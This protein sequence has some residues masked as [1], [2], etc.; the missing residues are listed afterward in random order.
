MKVTARIAFTGPKTLF[1][2]LKGRAVLFEYNQQMPIGKVTDIREEDNFIVADMEIIE[3]VWEKNK[4]V[5]D[6]LN[7]GYW[8]IEPSY[9]IKKQHI[10]NDVRV[11][12]EVE[13]LELS[14]C[15]KIE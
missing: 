8:S 2:H 6:I 12:D 13:V 1:E 15:P 5:F 14:I 9:I 11:I 4:H 10:E 7:S 3:N